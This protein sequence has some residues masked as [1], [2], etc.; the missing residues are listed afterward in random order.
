MAKAK[1]IGIE[2]YLA[3]QKEKQLI[4]HR[5]L[6]E[7]DDGHREM[8]FCLAVNL[9]ETDDLYAALES[10][11]R[12]TV[13]MTVTEKSDQIKQKL[14]AAAQQKGITLRLRRNTPAPL[15]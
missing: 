8:F 1:R 6:T 5:L 14:D 9:M 7:Y 11:D 12:E 3:G 13:N 4:L 15:R 2:N 10:T